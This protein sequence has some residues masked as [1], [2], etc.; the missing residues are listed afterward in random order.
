MT[1]VIRLVLAPILAGQLLERSRPFLHQ[2]RC[3]FH[4]SAMCKSVNVNFCNRGRDKD[5]KTYS[6]ISEFHLVTPPARNF[7]NVHGVISYSA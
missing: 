3:A 2:T 7:S 5:E 4:R 1:A 6:R